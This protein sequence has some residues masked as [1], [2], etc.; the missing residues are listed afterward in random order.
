[1][2][3]KQGEGKKYKLWCRESGKA[4]DGC[5]NEIHNSDKRD[6]LFRDT[7]VNTETELTMSRVELRIMRNHKYLRKE[8]VNDRNT[9]VVYKAMRKNFNKFNN[10]IWISIHKMDSK[11]LEQEN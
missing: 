6:T 10:N 8:Y 3:W 4:G 2:Q 5:I 1:M 9:R 11:A 7:G